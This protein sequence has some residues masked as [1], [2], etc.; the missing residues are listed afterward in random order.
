MEKRKGIWFPAKRCGW[1]WG[2]PCAWQGWVVLGVYV[3]L[4]TAAAAFA[5]KKGTAWFHAVFLVLSIIVVGIFWLK[6]ERP[7]RRR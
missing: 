5:P 3:G 4:V 2:L 6:G 1:G 7:E